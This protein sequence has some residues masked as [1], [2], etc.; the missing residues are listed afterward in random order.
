MKYSLSLVVFVAFYST[1]KAIDF[2][3]LGQS[4]VDISRGLA[5]SIPGSIINPKDLFECGKN[6]IAGYPF[7]QVFSVLNTFC[8]AALTTQNVK[9]NITPYVESMNFVL[10][11]KNQSISVPLNKPEQLWL[12]PEFNSS[13]PL[14]MMITGWSTN[15]NKSASSTLEKVYEAY[16]CRGGY[17]F[18]A[19]DSAAFIDTLYTWSA[20]NTEE[21][22]NLI[23]D[24]LEVLIQNY[25]I[26]KIH[27][28]GHSLGAHISGSAG[29][30]LFEKTGK[31]IPR[32]TGLDPANPC[33]NSGEALT[34]LGRGDAEFV[35]VIHSNSGG[36]GKRDPLGDSDWYP[37]G[38]NPLP[39]GCFDIVCA[40]TRAPEFYAESVYPGNENNFLGVKC[41]SLHA[42]N[43]DS[44][45]GKQYPMGYATP[46]NLKGNYFLKTNGK[47]PYGLNAVKGFTPFSELR[48]VCVVSKQQKTKMKFQNCQLI[49]CLAVCVIVSATV[50]SGAFE[51]D[52]LSLE[53]D[54]GRSIESTEM[55]AHRGLISKMIERGKLL[56]K[57]LPRTFKLAGRVFN[58]VPK[59]ESIFNIG[60]Q[61]LIG[62][63]QEAIAYA[64]NSVCS[65]AIHLN[66]IKPSI[67]PSVHLMNFQF[68]TPHGDTFRIPLLEPHKLW[69]NSKFNREWNTTL[70]ITG[71]N[72]N[73]NSTNEAVETLYRAYRQ[74][75]INFI[76]FDTSNFIDTLYTWSAFN[77]EGVG[78]IVGAA[79]AELNKVVDVKGIHLIGHSLGAHIAGIAG[80]QFTRLT[81]KLIP[82]VTG[83]DPARP[84]FSEGERLN[85]LQRGDASFVDIIHTNPGIL[86]IKES[87]GDI[88]FYPNGQYSL[89]PGCWTIMCAHSRAYEY[90]AETV[91]KN[92]GNNFIGT[93]CNSLSALRDGKC[94]IKHIPMGIDTPSTARGNYYLETN[95]KTPYGRTF[96]KYANVQQLAQIIQK[97]DRLRREYAREAL[98]V[99]KCLFASWFFFPLKLCV[100]RRLEGKMKCFLL[101]FLVFTLYT[102]T[103]EPL[104]L[105]DIG[106]S[107]TDVAKGVL[108]KIPDAIPKP[109]D[110]FQAGKN[111]I[112][113]YPFEQVFSAIN[114]F[115]SA[116]L[117][118]KNVQPRS[119]PNI[120]NMSYVLKTKNKNI[121]VPLDSPEELWSLKEFDPKLPL[122][123]VITGWTTNFNDTQNPTLDKIYDAYRC[124]GNV[125]FVTVD[126][127]G[128]VDTL[129][130]W[131]AFNTEEIGNVIAESLKHLIQSYPVEK[132]HLI[133]H[134]LG[135]HIAGSAGR[136]L[137]YKTNKLLPRITGLDPANPCF[138]QGENLTGLARGDA[139]FVMVIH[140]NSGALGKRDPLGDIDWYP[141]GVQPL[142]PGC[143]SI[144][145]AHQRAPEFYAESVYP[146]NENNF[147]GVKCGSLAAYS[148]KYCPG[149]AYPM[150]YATPQNLKGNFFLKT[151]DKSPFGLNATKD[152]KPVCVESYYSDNSIGSTTTSET[153]SV[154]S[155]TSNESTTTDSTVSTST[156]S[157]IGSF[158][159]NIWS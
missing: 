151:N 72:T 83:L 39:P 86:G 121:S 2:G 95:K 28:L 128:F 34:G 102:T 31:L 119:L 85:G 77:T 146:G 1:T 73:V 45:R 18:V 156:G 76:V 74:R 92:N 27:L 16:K 55:P 104:D 112:A 57:S 75:K 22:G 113:G 21:I 97:L 78:K 60:K 143:L 133:G 88:D 129:Y 82:R 138:N 118:T 61:A 3:G 98:H 109:E 14:V 58:L 36:L 35:D 53:R 17:N 108:E 105:G 141:N 114:T 15:F 69:N 122:V 71:W 90:F 26:E 89:Q 40:H 42:L 8:S 130:S 81:N 65:A 101:F 155:T 91:Y 41:G 96:T 115:C 30:N 137:N 33:F 59:P 47:S 110:L 44:C 37:N 48:H 157:T 7:N 117:S 140:S 87:R 5:E 124:R 12:L 135:A 127:A 99:S 94:A 6:I 139:D 126:T 84:C 144:S 136:N 106:K 50:V 120:G 66:V 10:R 79:I 67:T 123:M 29:R 103:V 24:A 32:I 100:V 159:K 148:A 131:S 49:V 107:A 64:V 11:I 70:V 9:P 149:R 52:A 132:I 147:M 20:F 125:N 43:T 152:F 93:Q 134:S 116:A 23:A 51:E 25:P 62:L 154:E 145:C 63:P 4:V 54:S 13:R 111:L 80:R 142:P 38:V 158:V 150:G 46:H 153:T 19:F 68:Y 56:I